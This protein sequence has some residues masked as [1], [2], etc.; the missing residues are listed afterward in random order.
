[1]GQSDVPDNTVPKDENAARSRTRIPSLRQAL[2]ALMMSDER[3][4]EGNPGDIT[5]GMDISLPE[6]SAPKS[7]DKSDDE[8]DHNTQPKPST[9]T[10][11]GVRK[12]SANT[13]NETYQGS[14]GDQMRIGQRGGQVPEGAPITLEAEP[15]VAAT[16]AV[17]GE[18][19]NSGK[20]TQMV[21]GAQ[22]IER[23]GFH[24]EPV[25]GWLVVIGGP[26]LGAHRPVY[27]GNNTLGRASSQ[28]IPIDFG[29]ESIS[30]E[31]Q[32]YIR[33][34]SS[35]KAFLLV[36]NLTK[37]NVVAVNDEKPTNAVPLKAMDVI[38]V[39]RTQLVFVPF[40]GPEFDWSELKKIQK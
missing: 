28:R 17:N 20:K 19:M 9:E 36:P 1:M 34:D 4:K 27:E 2:N 29:D 38:T 24:Q 22:E 13:N 35:D 12:M 32:V 21:R 37:T 33:Y 10:S 30:G 40:C 8:F 23:S 5:L 16:M 11:E 31:E 3:K 6:F 26:G 39:G 18:V 25:V 7:D 14:T 15:M